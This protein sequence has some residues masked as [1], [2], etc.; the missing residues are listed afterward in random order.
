MRVPWSLE[1]ARVLCNEYDYFDYLK[2]RV[3]KVRFQDGGFSA[4]LYNLDNGLN[5]AQ[6][7]VAELRNA[8]S[9]S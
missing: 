2:G 1:E 5:A 4:R 9:Q 3:M 7:I 6:E 8:G